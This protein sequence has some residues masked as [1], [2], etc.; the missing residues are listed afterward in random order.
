MQETSIQENTQARTYNLGELF[1]IRD[2]LKTLVRYGI[3]QPDEE[4]LRDTQEEI[5]KIVDNSR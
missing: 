5:G 4:L 1:E 2:A 3:L